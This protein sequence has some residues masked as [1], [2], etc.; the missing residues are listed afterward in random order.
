VDLVTLSRA[1]GFSFTAGINLYATVAIIGL[2][3]RY[4]WVDL[5]PQFQVFDNDIVIYGALAMY[6]VEFIADKIPWVDTLWDAVHT[7]VRPLGGA[8]IAVAAMGETTL[9]LQGVVALMGATVA[10]STHVTKAGSRA[11][12]NTSPEP[13]SNWGMSLVEDGLVIGMGFLTLMV[14]IAA[15]VVGAAV[16]LLVFAFSRRLYLGAKR[17]FS[18]RA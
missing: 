8:L 10:A 11:A 12:I 18:S 5:P 3:E 6:A 17:R 15:L 16:L 9:A 13:F 4:G 14:P 1:F 2:A 7:F